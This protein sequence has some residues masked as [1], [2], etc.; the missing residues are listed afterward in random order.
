MQ[1]SIREEIN[2]LTLLIIFA[3]GLG[4]V[5][6]YLFAFWAL[7][8]TLYCA[9]LLLQIR[10]FYLWLE[11]GG[12]NYPPDSGGIWGDI[13]DT[14]YRYRH[15]NNLIKEQLKHQLEH[16]QASMNALQSGVVS[17]SDNNY[18]Q[19]WNP[20]AERLLGFKDILDKGKP[21]NNLIRHPKFI[22]YLQSKEYQHTI[23][24]PSPVSSGDMVEIQITVF[25]NQQRLLMVK[26]I[27]R[28][29]R[30]EQ[31]RQD[32]VANVSHELRTP[33]TVI[34][35]YLE[36]IETNIEKIPRE[37]HTPLQ[38]INRQSARMTDIVDDLSILSRLD[39]QVSSEE[40]SSV[41]V[42]T[43]LESIVQDAQEIRNDIEPVINLK[44]EGFIIHGSKRELH[45]C[46]S[47]IIFNAIK[48]AKKETLQLTIEMEEINQSKIIRFI[49]DGMGIDPV[50]IPRLTE[51]FYRADKSHSRETGGTGL[52]L[53]IVKHVL[54]RHNAKLN[55]KSEVGKGSTFICSFI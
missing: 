13:F 47:N 29:I 45:S 26:D 30:L 20:E 42:K 28:L 40:R 19:W 1:Q 15:K 11:E 34:N 8:I 52:G 48:Y 43:L 17:I 4:I 16:V 41:D 39:N 50:H 46:F 31:T 33:L 25:G 6:E 5:T 32:F 9:W 35:G 23:T 12:D 3:T 37:W 53:A 21:I 24:I 18:I 27:S 49:D 22:D 7:A 36:I 54:L 44:G 2:R 55:I 51:R 14:I 38:K 10:K